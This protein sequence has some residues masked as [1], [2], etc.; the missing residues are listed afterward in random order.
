MVHFLG[1]RTRG[2]LGGDEGKQRYG[3]VLSEGGSHANAGLVWVDSDVNP[4]QSCYLLDLQ[5]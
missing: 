1:G 3:M 5:D 2:A 4:L